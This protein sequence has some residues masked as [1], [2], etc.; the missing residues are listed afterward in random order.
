MKRNFAIGMVVVTALLVALPSVA[1]DLAKKGGGSC[2]IEGTW[3][4]ANDAGLNFIFRIDKNA[5]GKHTV[6]ADGF[7]DPDVIVYCLDYTAWH[8]ELVK[9]APNTYRFRQ[10]ELC[11]PNPLVFGPIEGLLHWASEG[12]MTLTSC[13]QMDA[14]IPT[15]GAYFWGQGKEPFIDEFDIEF[16]LILGTFHRM[17]SP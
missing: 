4:G 17:A 6:V 7:S 13:N 2:G 15:N 12:E 11:D 10:I 1:Q 3:Y 8:G 14:Y 5:A 9:I 16:G